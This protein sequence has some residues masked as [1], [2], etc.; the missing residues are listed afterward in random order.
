MAGGEDEKVMKHCGI[1]FRMA[2]HVIKKQMR[3]KPNWL[4]DLAMIW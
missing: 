4:N 3:Y 2:K 1:S